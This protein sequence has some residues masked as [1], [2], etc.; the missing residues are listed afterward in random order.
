MIRTS[1]RLIG[2]GMSVLVMLSSLMT[3]TTC[4]IELMLIFFTLLLTPHHHPHGSFDPSAL[5][6]L[7]FFS[8]RSSPAFTKGPCS[9]SGNHCVG[10]GL[11]LRCSDWATVE[12]EQRP[13][14]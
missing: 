10:A 8:Q 9:P 2:S 11:G 4:S 3:S 1:S 14:Q 7:I 12:T 6:S 13:N 5:Q